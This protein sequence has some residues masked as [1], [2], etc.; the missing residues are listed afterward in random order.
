L[1]TISTHLRNLVEKKLI[2]EVL[3]PGSSAA[4]VRGAVRTRGGVTPPTRSPFTSYRAIH[5]PGAVLRSTYHGYAAAYPEA[6][7]LDML[8]DVAQT[9]EVSEAALRKLRELVEEEKKD[10]SR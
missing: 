3:R 4:P 10:T 5:T 6:N 8:V 7:R 9:L 2:E 1:T